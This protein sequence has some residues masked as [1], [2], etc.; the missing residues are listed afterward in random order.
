MRLTRHAERSA[1]DGFFYRLIEGIL[2]LTFV[3][4]LGLVASLWRQLASIL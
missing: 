2:L 1:S 4:V 3:Y